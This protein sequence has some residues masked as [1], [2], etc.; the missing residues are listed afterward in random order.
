MRSLGCLL[1]SLLGGRDLFKAL[2]SRFLWRSSLSWYLLEC[3]FISSNT[4][5][6]FRSLCR[7]VFLT[8]HSP[9][10]NRPGDFDLG[11]VN[12]ANLAVASQTPNLTTIPPYWRYNLLLNCHLVGE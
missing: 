10:G 1:L 4:V 11:S 3:L 7:V 2:A 9:G 5:A 12:A 6:S 8:Y